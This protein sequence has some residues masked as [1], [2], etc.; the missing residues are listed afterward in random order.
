[1][2]QSPLLSQIAVLVLLWAVVLLVFPSSPAPF[3]SV[4]ASNVCICECCEGSGRCSRNNTRSF[5]IY[6]DCTSGCTKVHSHHSNAQHERRTEDHVVVMMA[7]FLI[8]LCGN[9]WCVV[10]W[11]GDVGG[12]GVR[13]PTVS[14]TSLHASRRVP[15][16]MSSP[17]ALVSRLHHLLLPLTTHLPPLQSRVPPPGLLPSSPVAVYVNATLCCDGRPRHLGEPC[18]DCHLPSHCHYIGDA[19]IRKELQSTAEDVHQKGGIRRTAE[20]GEGHTEVADPFLRHSR[21]V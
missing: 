2:A 3:S 18:G 9:C 19:G 4:S 11:M 6:D 5:T 10:W 20:A 1:M 15:H 7:A 14:R 13:R 17:T 16:W 8:S 21:C 12:V